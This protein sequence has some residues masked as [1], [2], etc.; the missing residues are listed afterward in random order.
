M[1][2]GRNKT[3]T[4]KKLYK[5]QKIIRSL[6]R[7][8]ASVT[9]K[10]REMIVIADVTRG[11]LYE[12]PE[13][14]HCLA[15]DVLAEGNGVQWNVDTA[16]LAAK[17]AVAPLGVLNTLLADLREAWTFREDDFLEFLTSRSFTYRS[18]ERED[19]SPTWVAG[20]CLAD[21]SIVVDRMP[22]YVRASEIETVLRA[23]PKVDPAGRSFIEAEILFPETVGD[24]KCV[25]TTSEDA[26]VYAQRPGRYGLTRFVKGRAPEP[27]KSVFVVL[28]KERNHRYVLITGFTGGKPEPEP[29]DE[30]A[31]AHS[32]DPAEARKRSAEFWANHA[33]IYMPDMIVPGTETKTDSSR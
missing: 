23:L 22:S 7:H 11:C 29:W 19:P 31:F 30:K 27:T 13:R 1:V 12:T 17:L 16:Q 4:M 21:G 9:I 15:D 26:I 2:L 6:L 18:C 32:V 3:K 24:T 20:G 25:E 5:T 28:K 10:G 14:I 8:K 33:L